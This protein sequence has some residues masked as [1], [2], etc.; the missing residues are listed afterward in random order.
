MAIFRYENYQELA[1]AIIIQACKDWSMPNYRNAI[2][3]FLLSD[4]M[5]VLT[6]ISGEYIL[7]RLENGARKR[8]SKR[9]YVGKNMH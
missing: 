1:N 7:R 9:H 2:R 5:K 4:W 8:K 6:S 3:R